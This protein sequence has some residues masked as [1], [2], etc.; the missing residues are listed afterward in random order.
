MCGVVGI[1]TGDRRIAREETVRAMHDI[2]KQGKALYWG[3]S[4]WSADQVMQAWSIA[5]RHHLQKGRVE[6]HD[7]VGRIFRGVLGIEFDRTVL[8]ISSQPLALR[9]RHAQVRG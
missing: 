8:E 6:S 4:E 5:Q 3:T 7:L 1:Y 2:I 9:H